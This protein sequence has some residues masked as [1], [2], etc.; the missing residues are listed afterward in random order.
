MAHALRSG[1]Q[2]LEHGTNNS[3]QFLPALWGIASKV[4]DRPVLVE[5]AMG[6]G[7]GVL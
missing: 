7:D 2:H 6:G 3:L 5:H 4:W 1:D